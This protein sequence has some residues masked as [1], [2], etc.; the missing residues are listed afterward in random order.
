LEGF[1]ETAERLL[2]RGVVA[3]GDVVVEG[4]NVL[5]LVGLA[6][7]AD[8]DAAAFPGVSALLEGSV[9]DLAVDLQDAVECLALAAIRVQAVLV[10]QDHMNMLA[11]LFY[12]DKFVQIKRKEERHSPPR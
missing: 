2:E 7:V 3:P 9:V 4:A 10:A 11:H 8:A 5:E 1:V 6:N 12:I